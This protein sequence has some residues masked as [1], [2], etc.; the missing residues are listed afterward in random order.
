MSSH[1]ELADQLAESTR[2]LQ[3]AQVVIV[4][5]TA[6]LQ[7]NAS[8]LARQCDLTRDAEARQMRAEVERDKAREGEREELLRRVIAEG[9][10]RNVQALLGRFLMRAERA[11]A[12]LTALR[13]A[14]EEIAKGMRASTFGAMS[15][16]WKRLLCAFTDRLEALVSVREIPHEQEQKE[17]QHVQ[18]RT[19]DPAE[20]PTVSFPQGRPE[21]HTENQ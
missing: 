1:Q 4:A 5:L 18:S 8:M 13:G 15:Q 11:E 17:L 14:L 9:N 21:S 6:D 16:P 7:A 12:V 2:L 20:E 19:G 10:E 3:R